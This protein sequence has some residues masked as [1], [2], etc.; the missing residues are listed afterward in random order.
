MRFILNTSVKAAM[1]LSLGLFTQQAM[2][3]G[4]SGDLAS[5]QPKAVDYSGLKFNTYGLGGSIDF[6]SF[7]SDL[8]ESLSSQFVRG[9]GS[10]NSW[11][12]DL[13]YYEGT[14]N[15]GFLLWRQ[16]NL[17]L[18]ALA[19]IGLAY[20]KYAIT[21][22]SSKTTDYGIYG[23]VPVGAEVGYLIPGLNMSLFANAGYKYAKDITGDRSK[24]ADGTDTLRTRYDVCANNG[25][26]NNNSKV[27]LGNLSGLQFGVGTRVHF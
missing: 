25:G 23:V 8:T 10:A 17:S 22:P 5:W 20:S 26:F 2:A 6:G 15:L 3:W 12:V 4:L 27:V 13:N 18:R 24:C 7:D 19:G 11:D 21:T 9:S 16:D 14:A 1:V